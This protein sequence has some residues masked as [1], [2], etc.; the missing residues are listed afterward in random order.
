MG[1]SGEE[2]LRDK[3]KINIVVG[4]TFH[5]AMLVEKLKNLGYDIKIYT[6]TPKFKFKKKSFY[7]QPAHHCVLSEPWD[8]HA[9]KSSHFAI[10][11][12]P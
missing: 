6:S 7:D 2:K 3:I 4:G 8:V 12:F 11:P 9:P 1:G 10:A 5:I